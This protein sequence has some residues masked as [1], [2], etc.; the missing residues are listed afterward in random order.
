MYHVHVLWRGF[1][2]GSVGALAHPLQRD[3]DGRVGGGDPPSAIH[4]RHSTHPITPPFTRD[5]P[6]FLKQNLHTSGFLSASVPEHFPAL[7]EGDQLSV[8]TSTA[9]SVGQPH[10]RSTFRFQPFEG[11]AEGSLRFGFKYYVSVHSDLHERPVG[12][13]PERM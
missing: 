13:A 9:E 6:R 12:V 1:P 10:V 4:A 5:N 2:L 11:D 3:A 8:T 7:G